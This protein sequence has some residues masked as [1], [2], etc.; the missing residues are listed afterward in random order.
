MEI[1]LQVNSVI[2]FAGNEYSVL[3]ILPFN[4]SSCY[5]KLRSTTT[6]KIIYLL[7]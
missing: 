1:Q 2:K 7:L 4:D 5:Y 3:E 6:D